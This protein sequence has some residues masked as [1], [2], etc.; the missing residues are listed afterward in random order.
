[1]INTYDRANA[2]GSNGQAETL[3]FD[4]TGTV[5]AYN[6]AF[7]S[8]QDTLRTT[9]KTW[10]YKCYVE[11]DTDFIWM[12]SSGKV[13]LYEECEIVSVYDPAASNHTSYIGAP[14]MNI[15]SKAGKG[16]V[17]FNSTVS[18]QKNQVTFFGRTP[19]TSG[20]LNQIA[21]VNVKASGIN[22]AVWSGKPL[23]AEGI[24]QN[25]RMENG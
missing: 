2:T 5:A 1:M 14:R 24:A 9:G 22:P 18:S 3:G 23:M 21:F 25:V 13:A 19:W 15:G 16:L 6:C 17:V 7:K 4:G 11:G 12:E 20:Y 10:F 8:H